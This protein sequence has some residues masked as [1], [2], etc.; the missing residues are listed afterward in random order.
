MKIKFGQPNPSA[1]S[2]RSKRDQ[3]DKDA[4][5]PRI[6]QKMLSQERRQRKT[7]HKKAQTEDKERRKSELTKGKEKV[8]GLE[9]HKTE[10]VYERN[11]RKLKEV[12]EMSAKTEE[13]S[14]S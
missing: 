3:G 8:S 10:D 13:S 9:A 5:N 2:Y 1:S 6:Q 11:K 7:P 4:A 12:G 14:L